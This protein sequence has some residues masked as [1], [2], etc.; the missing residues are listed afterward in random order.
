LN[1]QRSII[2]SRAGAAAALALCLIFPVSITAQ[3]VSV[4][5]EPAETRIAPGEYCTLYVHVDDGVDSLSCAWCSLGFDST[6]VSCVS[7]RKGELYNYAAFPTF[8]DWDIPSADTVSV[9]A[10]VLGYRSYIIP[11]GNL[12][13]ITFEALALGVTDVEFGQLSV[14]DIDRGDLGEDI[15]HQGRIIVTTQTGGTVPP[16]EGGRLSNYPNPFNPATTI[17]LELPAGSGDGRSTEIDIY[18]AAGRTVRRLFSGTAPAGRSEIHWDGTSDAGS[19]VSSGLYMA[20]SRTG[21]LRLERKLVL[22]R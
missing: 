1:R 17:V 19:A 13:E 5:I 11:P 3:T 20:V 6:V 16:A 22:I 21:P 10:C 2:S 15:V 7:A 9:T 4:W 14:F 18:D 12:F 8:F